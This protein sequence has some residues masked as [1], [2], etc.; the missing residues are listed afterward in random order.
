VA[1][2]KPNAAG[3]SYVAAFDHAF[4][5]PFR[6]AI[7]EYAK[8]L[9]LQSGYAVQG[10][11]DINSVRHLIGPFEAIRSP[12]VR[13]VS[14]QG[15]VQTTKSLVA[16]LVVP[17]W[18]E[19]DPGDTLWL[20]EDDAKAK[21]YADTRAMQLIK[22][23][24]EIAAMLQD[25][26]RHDKAKTWFK[27]KHMNL[28]FAGLNEGN[29]QSLSWRYVIIDEPW[30][31]GTDGLLRQA[32]YRTT[33]Y[34]DTCKVLVISQGGLEGCDQDVLH[35]ETNRQ[36]L[37]FTCP[38]CG[39]RQPFELSRF[40]G[41]DHSVAGL[42]GTYSGLSWD[43]NELTKP[44]GK[45]DFERV[46]RTAHH[47]C[48]QCD[49]RIEDTPD[50]RRQLND[51]YAY[52]VTNPGAESDKVG[53]QWPGEA[54]MRIPFARMAVRY[55]R[56]KVA[57]DELSYKLPMQEYYQKDRGLTWNENA[58]T[59][60][61]PV[62]LVDYDVKSDWSEEAHRFLIGDCQQGLT[63]FHIGVFACALS[64]ET[65]ELARETVDSFDAITKLQTEWK[66]HDQR[67]FL[68]CGYEMTEVLR[69]C[70]RRGH[71][72]WKTIGGR[73]VKLWLCWTGLKGSA[74]ETFAHP[75]WVWDRKTKMHVRAG[76]EQRIYSPEKWYHV[77]TS[78]EDNSKRVL[79]VRYYEF[80]NLHCKDLLRAR[81][82]GDP[83]APKLLFLP[84]K[85][86]KEDPWSHWAQM[87]SEQR[88]ARPGGKPFWDHPDKTKPNHEWDKCQML[89]AVQAIF[90]IIGNAAEPTEPTTAETEAK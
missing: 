7:Y 77:S 32:I 4:R 1:S 68:D 63:K 55:L 75:L 14:I 50:I 37:E 56:A 70:H 5:D 23:K 54:S 28:L 87:R 24:P 39:H 82:D 46:G 85:L 69:E 34:P 76:T 25:I 88:I 73:K 29:V 40:R 11:F 18:I 81:R 60:Y 86:P 47:R 62:T 3:R 78:A 21:Q 79:R 43:T 53:F 27:L 16:D 61:K 80:S 19:H 84:D 22:S 41:E 30:M 44:N 13:L 72:G 12:S 10:H 67:V 45:W 9:D 71:E 48:Y 51:S 17:Y 38:E 52:R 20:F 2:V 58:E 66:V 90:G 31:H 49:A 83:T 15:G 59:Q 89:I 64:G 42:R 8:Q 35:K 36:V 74:Q 33:Q 6:G 26:D 57:M 65:R